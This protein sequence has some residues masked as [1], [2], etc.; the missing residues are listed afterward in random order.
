MTTG[1][2]RPLANWLVR[3]VLVMAGL[4]AWASEAP[5]SDPA[6]P[7]AELHARGTFLPLVYD[8]KAREYLAPTY[9][10]LPMQLENAWDRV[11]EDKA[12]TLFQSR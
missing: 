2:L 1:R 9:Q 11:E 4:V 8:E 12:W 7:M 6:R 5:A 3:F 10:L